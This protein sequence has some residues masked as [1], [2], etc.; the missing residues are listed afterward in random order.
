MTRDGVEFTAVGV[1][2]QIPVHS[3]LRDSYNI[4]NYLA[5]ITS[6]MITLGI[7]PEFA[8]K[9]IENLRYL[10]GR[11]ERI[12]LG[13]EF[14][15]IVDFAHTPN[16]LRKSLLSLRQMLNDEN[17]F[18]RVI[19]VFGSVGLR[20][21]AKRRMMAEISAELADIII[22]TAEDPRTEPL[23][24]ILDEMSSGCR[25]KNGVEGTTFWRIRDRGEAIRFAVCLAHDGDAVVILGKG[26]EQSMCFGETEYAWDDRTALSAAISQQ[27]GITGPEMPYLP[28]RDEA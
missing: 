25:A 8:A 22:L 27:M 17:G 18:G 6:T 3:W 23:D 5:A 24:E 2:F 15:T 4:P 14:L 26:H 13:T 20:D 21:R 9:G 12:D 19:A 28:T 11:M 16:A 10:P 7:N 1:D